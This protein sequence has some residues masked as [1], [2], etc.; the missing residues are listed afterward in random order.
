MRVGRGQH[1]IQRNGHFALNDIQCIGGCPRT[2]FCDM[3]VC[4]CYKSLMALH[5]TC[6]RH[7]E[8]VIEDAA[9]WELKKEQHLLNP[10]VKSC[11]SHRT[12][13]E[14]DIN[15]ICHYGT[16]KC[17]C[18]EAMRWNADESEC[19]VFVVSTPNHG[20]AAGLSKVD[21]SALYLLVFKVFIY[22]HSRLNVPK[23]SMEQ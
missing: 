17:Q 8:G 23:L 4:R 20:G 1:F 21:H 2:A 16:R 3:G 18:R 15:L 12:C 11:S 7:H 14:V 22:L 5:G 9:N 6:W 13:H 10:S 19:Q